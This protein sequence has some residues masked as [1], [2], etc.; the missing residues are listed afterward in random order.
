VW[1][2]FVECNDEAAGGEE[3]RQNVA[4]DVEFGRLLALVFLPDDR[5][6]EHVERLCLELAVQ[7]HGLASVQ[8][9]DFTI[10]PHSQKR[11]TA[12]HCTYKL[13]KHIS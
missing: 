10:R 9:V 7:L 11:T 8:D 3:R 4:H 5:V 12:N 2:V 13:T 6:L 1:R